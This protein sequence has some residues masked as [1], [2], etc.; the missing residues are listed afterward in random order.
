MDSRGVDAGLQ[1]ERTRLAWQRTTLTGL[2]ALL[3]VLRLLVEVSPALA[4]LSTGVVAIALAG[5]VWSATRWQVQHPSLDAARRADG[6][7]AAVLALI[8]A[9]ACLLALAYV[10]VS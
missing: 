8:V 7:A 5:P 10:V 4:L 6:R 9:L 1:P 3:I 2:A